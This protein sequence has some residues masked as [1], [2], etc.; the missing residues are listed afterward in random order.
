MEGRH[1]DLRALGGKSRKLRSQI[2]SQEASTQGPAPTFPQLHAEC[3]SSTSCPLTTL[4]LWALPACWLSGSEHC[5]VCLNSP[6][7]QWSSRNCWGKM[8]ICFNTGLCHTRSPTIHLPFSFFLK[9]WLY[10]NN[11]W[12]LWPKIE[13]SLFI[14]PNTLSF[15][16]FFGKVN[17]LVHFPKIL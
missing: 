14:N 5:S 8:F 6:A 16:H 10:N 12:L 3:P 2:H 13:I 9:T 7:M 17:W 4:C 15:V 1:K 11:F